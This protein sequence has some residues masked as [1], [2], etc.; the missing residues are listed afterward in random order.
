M[1]INSI[2]HLNDFKKILLH[3]NGKERRNL[4]EYVFSLL[5]LLYFEM[6]K[7]RR[8]KKKLCPMRNIHHIQSNTNR[9]EQRMNVPGSLFFI[10]YNRLS[11]Q[12]ECAV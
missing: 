11:N 8:N 7:E 4:I 10:V 2:K 3:N 6:E 12:T 1:E 5:I 9:S